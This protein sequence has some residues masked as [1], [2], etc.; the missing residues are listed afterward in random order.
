[1]ER[2]N[3]A[4]LNQAI[5]SGLGRYPAAATLPRQRVRSTTPFLT[6]ETP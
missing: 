5:I 4:I 1:M 2:L 6:L 3:T